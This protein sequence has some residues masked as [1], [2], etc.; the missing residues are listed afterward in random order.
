ML[1]TSQFDIGNILSHLD[2]Q[3][4]IGEQGKALRRRFFEID[5]RELHRRLGIKLRNR[6]ELGQLKASGNDDPG[7]CFMAWNYLENMPSVKPLPTPE[8]CQK[9]IR[10]AYYQ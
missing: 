9:M 8:E 3:I 6:Y 1:V 5:A 4:E 7:A 10:D 2:K